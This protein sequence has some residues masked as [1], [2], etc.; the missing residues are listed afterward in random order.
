M[1]YWYTESMKSILLK[2]AISIEIDSELPLALKT[3]LQ[4]GFRIEEEC[5]LFNF[6]EYY[7]SG[8]LEYPNAKNDYELFLNSIPIDFSLYGCSDNQCLKAGLQFCK[9]LFEL[10][11]ISFKFEFRVVLEFESQENWSNASCQVS[12][13]KIRMEI[14]KVFWPHLQT[15]LEG[16]TALILQ[17]HPASE[18]Q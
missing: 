2:E 12:F 5:I 10:L 9:E 18:K 13:H 11:A 3:V 7:G 15:L 1:E 16:E 14:D 17:Y 6:T 4:Q 8:S